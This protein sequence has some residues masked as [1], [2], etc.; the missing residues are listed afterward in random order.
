MVNI[1][2]IELFKK[3]KIDELNF[4]VMMKLKWHL[5]NLELVPILFS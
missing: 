4:I 5:K 2:N 1:K 3:W